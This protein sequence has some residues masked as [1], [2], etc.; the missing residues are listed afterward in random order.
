MHKIAYEN[1]PRTTTVVIAKTGLYMYLLTLI[2]L[3]MHLKYLF[4]TYM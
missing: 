2:R 1:S 3:K 4:N